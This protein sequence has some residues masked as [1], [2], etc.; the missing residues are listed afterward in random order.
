MA[1]YQQ[2]PNSGSLFR[3]ER[4]TTEKHPEY[5]GSFNIDGG[6]YWI[7]G[8]AKTAKSGKKFISLAVSA[9][10]PKAPGEALPPLE[11]DDL[12]F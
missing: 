10:Q 1:D 2:F 11:D 8:W 5:Q 3:N 12:P 6:E 4:K 9:K 7:S